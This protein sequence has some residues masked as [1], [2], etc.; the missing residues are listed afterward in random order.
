MCLEKKNKC[1]L[2]SKSPILTLDDL[3]FLVCPII[4]QVKELAIERKIYSS[5]KKG[6]GIA[7]IQRSSNRL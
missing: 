7:R 5:G 1:V 2:V 3:I 6:T 4:F